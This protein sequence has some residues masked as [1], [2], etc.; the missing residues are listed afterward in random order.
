MAD[1]MIP[2]RGASAAP[3]LDVKDPH[4][5]RVFWRNLDFL[6]DSCR[7]NDD[8]E[9]KK[10]VTR[11]APLSEVEIWEELAEFTDNTKTYNDFK[12]AVNELYPGTGDTQKYDIEDLD[13]IVGS[14]A[15]PGMSTLVEFADYERNFCHV[16]KYL[17]DQGILSERERNRAFA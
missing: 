1:R 10:H 13:L 9:K 15:W 16:A 12:K 4:T 14:R 5:I 8:L 17:I 6:F 3:K 2:A 7:V 11:L